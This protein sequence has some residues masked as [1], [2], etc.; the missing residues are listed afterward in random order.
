MSQLADPRSLA[1]SLGPQL[2]EACEGR[3]STITWFRT[4]WQ[5]GGAATG[6]AR[7]A[8]DDGEPVEVV[9]KVP[10]V[11]REVLWLRRLQDPSAE[12]VIPRLYASGDE[13]GGYDLAW[14][15][16]ECFPQGPLG[17]HWHEDHIPRIV[18]DLGNDV[19]HRSVQPALPIRHGHV[20][21]RASI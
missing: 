5:R 9:V 1:A 4:D 19:G 14:V 2:D 12:G 18:F 20:D 7:Y 17:T 16:I 6:R 10:V 15:V 13:V 11:Q 8:T 21:F 3:L